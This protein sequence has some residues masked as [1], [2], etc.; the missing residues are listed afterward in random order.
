MPQSTRNMIPKTKGLLGIYCALAV[1]STV[2]G[3]AI[4]AKAVDSTEGRVTYS[5]R[6]R[7]A[8][9]LKDCSRHITQSRNHLADNNHMLAYMS[10]MHADTTIKCCRDLVGESIGNIAK[11]NVD[12]M[13]SDLHQ[14]FRE[15][16]PFMVE[17]RDPVDQYSST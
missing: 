8:R 13:E 7:L 14:L 3:I 4:I 9:K 17:M 2:L 5:L 6:R 10:A 1:V 11:M 15:I 16:Q 12:S